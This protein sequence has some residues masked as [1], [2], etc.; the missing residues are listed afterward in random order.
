VDLVYEYLKVMRRL[1]RMDNH[2]TYLSPRAA[3]RLTAQ[4]LADCRKADRLY[5]QMNTTQR[6]EALLA[7]ARERGA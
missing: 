6:E 1:R 4:T 5:D 3:N 7:S 2:A